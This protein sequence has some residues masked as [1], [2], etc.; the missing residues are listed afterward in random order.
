MIEILSVQGNTGYE[1]MHGDYDVLA[2]L[3]EGATAGDVIRA[4]FPNERFYSDGGWIYFEFNGRSTSFCPEAFWNSPYE[5]EK[6][7]TMDEPAPV[8]VKNTDDE[9]HN[10]IVNISSGE[11]VHTERV[12]GN[13]EEVRDFMCLRMREDIEENKAEFRHGTETPDKIS[14]SRGGKFLAKRLSGS[15]TFAYYD[16]DYTAM[17]EDD[18]KLVDLSRTPV[19][20][21]E[22]DER[23]D[24]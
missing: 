7:E 23:D 10:W 3:P 21:I 18:L 5:I 11:K 9:H 24:R 15:L 19:P 6:V 14:S 17:R 1:L 12:Y 8:F 13:E 22:A 16:I 2:K 20:K 4:A